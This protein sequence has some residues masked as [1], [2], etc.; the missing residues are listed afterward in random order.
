MTSINFNPFSRALKGL[1]PDPD[2]DGHF[3]GPDM[4][5]NCEQWL[6][7]KDKSR[8]SSKERVNHFLKI[9]NYYISQMLKMWLTCS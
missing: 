8:H 7:A 1:G 9:E 3:V 5:P 6:S 2:Q 4:G